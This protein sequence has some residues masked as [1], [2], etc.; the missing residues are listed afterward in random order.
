[1]EDVIVAVKSGHLGVAGLDPRRIGPGLE[2]A[3]HRPAAHG[4]CDG[5]RL[6]RRQAMSVQCAGPRIDA[7]WPG[8]LMFGPT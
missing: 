3:A 2:R 8:N 6:D 5:E 1:M 4:H 7:G